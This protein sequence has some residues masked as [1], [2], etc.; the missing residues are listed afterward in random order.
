M[1]LIK[2]RP[3]S[4]ESLTLILLPRKTIFQGRNT[5]SVSLKIQQINIF[6]LTKEPF[7]NDI[8]EICV[9]SATPV[10]L[11]CL[12]PNHCQGTKKCQTRLKIAGIEFVEVIIVLVVL[13]RL[14]IVFFKVNLCPPIILVLVVSIGLF[15]FCFVPFSYNVVYLLQ[16]NF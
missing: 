5:S 4:S 1:R 8:M 13:N 2:S 16:V 14:Y 7:I 12:S 9:V 6:I 10:M 3:A 11:L 15:W